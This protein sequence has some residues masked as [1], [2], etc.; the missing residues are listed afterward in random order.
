MLAHTQQEFQRFATDQAYLGS[1][2]MANFTA[3]EFELE[4]T[5]VSN[6][7]RD[8][9]GHHMI[10]VCLNTQPYHIYHIH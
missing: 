9:V 4:A 6:V 1:F 5:F 8:V 3:Y 7:E 2:R 10:L